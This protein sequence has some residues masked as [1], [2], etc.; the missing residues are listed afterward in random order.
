MAMVSRKFYTNVALLT[1]YERGWGSKPFS[2]KHFP[3][4]EEA[5]SFVNKTNEKNNLATVPDYYISAQFVPEM[6]V[7]IFESVNNS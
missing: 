4:K 2:A 6:K 1:E 3:T 5:V 7:E